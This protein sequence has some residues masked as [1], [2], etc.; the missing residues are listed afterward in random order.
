MEVRPSLWL[1]QAEVQ[2]SL[3]QHL[4]SCELPGNWFS[5]RRGVGGTTCL[6]ASRRREAR[7]A[8]GAGLRS[9]SCFGRHS[10]RCRCRRLVLGHL[11][12]EHVQQTLDT[13]V[14]LERDALLAEAF[15]EGRLLELQ[16]AERLLDVVGPLM[17]AELCQL[18]GRW[19]CS[20]HGVG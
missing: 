5:N 3:V 11:L 13:R 15:L 9:G 10:R 12:R 19:K 14:R 6:G 16:T 18:L 17:E 8:P 2:P 4:G 7:A 20:R 1:Q